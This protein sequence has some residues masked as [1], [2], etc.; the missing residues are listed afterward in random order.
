MNLRDTVL[1]T[2]TLRRAQLQT[3]ANL[4]ELTATIK[5]PLTPVRLW[6]PFIV[7]QTGE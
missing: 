3:L 5:E 7:Q 1:V 6:A 4:R 2:T